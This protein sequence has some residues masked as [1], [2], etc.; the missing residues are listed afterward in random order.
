MGNSVKIA[1]AYGPYSTANRLLDF[2]DDKIFNDSIGMTGS[3]TSCAMISRE[4]FLLGHD[5]TIFAPVVSESDGYDWDGVK[6]RSY[7]DILSTI[8]QD[9]HAI[10]SWNEPELLR[11]VT[12]RT[13]RMCNLQIND[14][15]HCSP[16]FDD[17][18]DLWTSPS[19]SHRM[20]VGSKSPNPG[21]WTV[22][23][24]G[25]D[26]TLYDPT[27]SVPGRVV[28]ASSPDR[29]LHWL[30]SIWPKIKKEVPWAELR[31]H[32]RI[33][34]WV[35][36]FIEVD[37]VHN[38]TYPELKSRAFYIRESIR[39][40]NSHGVKF[41]DSVSRNDMTKV[42]DEAQ[43]LAYPCD[44]IGYTEGF[45]VSIM[46]A[47]ASGTVPVI[48][49]TDALG[50]IYGEHVPMIHGRI[51]DNLNEYTEL[52][53]RSLK[54]DSFRNNSIISCRSLANKYTWKSIA[55]NVECIIVENRKS[56]GW[57]V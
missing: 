25:C 56:R 39:K 30:L 38:P 45:S 28:W 33:N 54:D 43:V 18:V 4:L 26:P 37:P 34:S 8:N 31:I 48:T 51:S 10:Y 7:R 46:E 32:Y 40:M 36:H 41:M 1:I 2:R 19:E 23:N 17:H 52:V 44:P 22:V 6:I 50:E 57:S 49:D 21:K 24:N 15:L 11:E 29:G 9:W 16:G 12:W 20:N 55:K 27:K 5:V 14:F 35:N 53:I 42:W 13:L 47:C 3:E